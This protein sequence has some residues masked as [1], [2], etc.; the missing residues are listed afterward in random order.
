MTKR[1]SPDLPEHGDRVSAALDAVYNWSYESELEELRALYIKGLNL[2]WIAQE[3]LSWDLEIDKEAFARSFTMGGI[4]IQETRFWQTLPAD[5]RWEVARRGAA[6]MLSN[7]LHGEQGALMVA[8]QLVNAVPHM[9]GKFYAATQTVDEAR[10]VEVFARYIDKLDHV[11]PIAPSLKELLDKTLM[12]DGWMFKAVGM[13]VVVEG[14]ALYTFRDMRE[15]TQEPLLKQLLTYVAR[16]EARHTAFG[17]KYLSSVVPQLEPHRVA[18][19]EDFAFEATR[20]LLDSRRGATLND[21]MM[22]ILI[23]A[24]LDPKDV[25]AG[26]SRDQDKLAAAVAKRGGRLGPV[27]GFVVPT[28]RRIGLFSDRAQGHFREMFDAMRITLPP[29]A[30]GKPAINPLDRLVEVPEDLEAWATGSA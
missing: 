26:L 25:A 24:G 14:L 7:I 15:T 19:L 16:D 4:P 9:D 22:T 18:E 17:I 13:Q 12:V 3:E 23:E 6:F 2:Q 20:M 29:T 5:K 8:S 30:D 28:L 10:H 21:A 11:Y 1:L 27:S